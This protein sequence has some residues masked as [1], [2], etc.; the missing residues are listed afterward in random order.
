MVSTVSEGKQMGLKERL[1][2]AIGIIRIE[3]TSLAK[4]G[5][6]ADSA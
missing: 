5:P 6:P 2:G 3:S 4:I 1:L